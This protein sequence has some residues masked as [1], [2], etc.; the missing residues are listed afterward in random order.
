V[1]GKWFFHKQAKCVADLFWAIGAQ[2]DARAITNAI[3]NV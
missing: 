2:R 3:T 1:K